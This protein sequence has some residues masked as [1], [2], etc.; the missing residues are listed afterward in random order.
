MAGRKKGGS[1]GLGGIDLSSTDN[2]VR[3]TDPLTAAGQLLQFLETQ[4]SSHR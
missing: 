1:R 3:D 2:G 4:L